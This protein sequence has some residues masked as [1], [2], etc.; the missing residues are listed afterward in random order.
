MQNGRLARKE[1]GTEEDGLSHELEID[2]SV[3][4]EQDKK[5]EP[6]GPQERQHVAMWKK[7][8]GTLAAIQHWQ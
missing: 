7:V 8:A 6:L 2:G 5:R 3:E 4:Q 1:E